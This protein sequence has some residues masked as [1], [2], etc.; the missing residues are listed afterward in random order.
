MKKFVLALALVICSVFATQAEIIQHTHQ[1]AEVKFTGSSYALGR[2]VGE[3]AQDQ[4]LDGIG[5]FN[6]TL[7]VMLPGLSVESLSRNFKEKGVYAKLEQSSPDAAAYIKGLSDALGFEPDYL[8]SVGMSDEAILES[9]RNGGVGFL[10]APAKCTVMGRTDSAGQAWAAANFDYMGVNYKGLIVLNHTNEDGQTKVIQTWAGLIP[11]G[12]ITVGGQPL[13]MNTMADEGTYREKQKGNILAEG[14]VPSFHLSWEAYN[15]SS[16]EELREMYVHGDYTA[17]F[18]YIMV[19]AEGAAT[20]FENAYGDDKLRVKSSNAL[21]HSNHSL[22]VRHDFVDEKFGAHSLKRQAAADEFITTAS[23]DV[24]HEEVI[25]FLQ[26]K[27]LWKGRDK[28]MGT[29]TST[30]FQVAGKKVDMYIH[31]DIG[32]EPVHIRNY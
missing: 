12:G 5:R 21:A 30:Y 10:E 7:G 4:I 32:Q 20:N 16:P 8:L 19:D 28:F 6:K 13:L 22:F 9:Q 17:F 14:A 15:Q 1:I 31:T 25:A 29:V 18:S 26:S 23:M 3:V 2:H 27:P 11:Y 24:S